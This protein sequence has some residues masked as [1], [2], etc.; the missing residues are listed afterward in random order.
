MKT[1]LDLIRIHQT[2]KIGLLG[3]LKERWTTADVSSATATAVTSGPAANA[4]KNGPNNNYRNGNAK[5]VQ[6]V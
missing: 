2:P 3:A 5:F 4:I 6:D 1:A